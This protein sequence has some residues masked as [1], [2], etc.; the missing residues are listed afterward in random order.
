MQFATFHSRRRFCI[1]GKCELNRREPMSLTLPSLF[2]FGTEDCSTT[3]I[4]FLYGV[5]FEGDLFRG[6]CISKSNLVRK[7]EVS[8]RVWRSTPSFRFFVF[9][10]MRPNP[11][12]I[13]NTACRSKSRS[14]LALFYKSVY[15]YTKNKV[16]GMKKL[17]EC[18]FFTFS[19]TVGHV[20]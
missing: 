14:G 18:L 8:F 1:I 17:G 11:P 20:S 2:L 10:C 3:N 5:S 15:R 19:F 7:T 13:T 12:K 16:Q 4:S 9:L 6:E